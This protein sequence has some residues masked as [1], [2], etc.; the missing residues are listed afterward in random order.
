MAFDPTNSLTAFFQEAISEAIR[1]QGVPASELTEFYLVRLLADYARTPVDDEPLAL[2]MAQAQV[3]STEERARKLRDIGDRSL[4]VSGFFSDS[5]NR[6]LVDVDYYIRMGGSAYRQL[7]RLPARVTS[8]FSPVYGELSEGFPRFVD[9]LAEVSESSALSSD[10]GVVQLYERYL[11]TGSEW[12]ARRL[13]ARG[14]LPRP[15]GDVQ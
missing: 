2:Q 5:L 10:R 1:N 14:V 13:R 7:A 6:S 15:A 11:K 12:I 4:Y 8:A 3:A 9:V